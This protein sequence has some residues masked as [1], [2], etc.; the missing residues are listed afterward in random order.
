VYEPRDETIGRYR[1]IATLGKGGMA[2]LFV[3]RLA[4]SGRF[5]KLVREPAAPAP[6][7]SGIRVRDAAVVVT[8]APPA[9]PPP[10]PSPVL[11]PL[12]H[13]PEA[14]VDVAPLPLTRPAPSRMPLVVAVLFVLSLL[15]GI[16][17]ALASR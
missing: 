10:S 4:G 16:I 9:P 5:E 1:L 12:S 13:E 17:A 3:A 6:R 8:S 7:P 2:E 11:P 15:V 14:T